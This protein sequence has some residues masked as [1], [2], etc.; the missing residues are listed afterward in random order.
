L[1]C[2]SDRRCDLREVSWSSPA[3]RRK[4]SDLKV[5]LGIRGRLPNTA[6]KKQFVCL[7]SSPGERCSTCYPNPDYVLSPNRTLPVVRCAR[8]GLPSERWLHNSERIVEIGRAVVECRLRCSTSSDH[9]PWACCRAVATDDATCEKWRGRHR[10]RVDRLAPSKSPSLSW[11]AS[12]IRRER[13]RSSG[14]CRTRR[15]TYTSCPPRWNAA[16]RRSSRQWAA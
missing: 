13:S 9:V 6:G 10:H 15:T 2:G 11:A 3:Q 1:P 14:R 16:S 12:P 7:F 8:R 5:D 4:S